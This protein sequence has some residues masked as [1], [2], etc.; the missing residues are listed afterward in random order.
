ME[1][2]EKPSS[3]L[4]IKQTQ[5]SITEIIKLAWHDIKGTKRTFWAVTALLTVIVCS[6]ILIEQTITLLVPYQWLSTTLVLTVRAISTIVSILLGLALVYLGLQRTSHLTIKLGMIN[7]VF[8]FTLVMKMIGLHIL[9][10]IILAPFAM[11]LYL[12]GFSTFFMTY[13]PTLA[14]NPFYETG[15]WIIAMVSLIILIHLAIRLCLSRAIIIAEQIT[16]WAAIRTSF[17]ATKTHVWKLLSLFVINFL[18]L[19]LSTIPFGI[20]LLWSIP[21]CFINYAL[22]YNKLHKRSL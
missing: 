7:D 3:P 14:L 1:P 17:M 2:T 18:V 9:E 15:R 20:G 22:V 16:P 21:F 19:I 4:L 13:F 8:D 11:L 5:F 12:P 10:F 6:L